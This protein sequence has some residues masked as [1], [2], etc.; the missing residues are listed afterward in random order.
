MAEDK[1]FP[2]TIAGKEKL[3]EKLNH[4]ITVD[5]VDITAE[6]Q[7]AR[8]HGDLSEN[9]EYQSAKDR[10]A[11]AEGEIKELQ[12]ILDAVALIDPANEPADEVT[13]GKKVEIQEDGD[14]PETFYVWGAEEIRFSNV[15]NTVKEQFIS[16]ESP[17]GSALLHHKQGDV[18]TIKVP[19]AGISYDV[20]I[21]N[22]E[23]A[24]VAVLY[25]ETAK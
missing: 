8:S 25:P 23:L 12:N 21:V 6:I 9:S 14:D 20:K 16:N 18:V 7:E 19:G 10:Q 4:K 17:L 11:F 2:M 13:L 24:N 1:K 22:V 5:R 15:D 3:E